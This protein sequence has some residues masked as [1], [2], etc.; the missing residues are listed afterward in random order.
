MI[1]IIFVVSMV[2]VGCIVFVEFIIGYDYVIIIE[3]VYVI[4]FDFVGDGYFIGV[5]DGIYIVIFDGEIGD[6]V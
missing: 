4:V 5:Y 6:C 3:Y 2:L 1:V